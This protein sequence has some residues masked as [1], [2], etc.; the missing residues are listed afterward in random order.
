MLES[1]G[2]ARR[3]RGM[4]PER[5]WLESQSLAPGGEVS[6]Q[7]GKLRLG[8]EGIEVLREKPGWW[9][10]KL[11]V[12]GHRFDLRVTEPGRG[13]FDHPV[14]A[15]KARGFPVSV[16]PFREAYPG[17]LARLRSSMF[18]LCELSEGGRVTV[19]AAIEDEPPEVEVSGYLAALDPAAR[20]FV[21]W[22]QAASHEL[23]WAQVEA[24]KVTGQMRLEGYAMRI[25]IRST[26]AQVVTFH[27]SG[28]QYYVRTYGGC[29]AAMEHWYGPYVEGAGGHWLAQ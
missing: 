21:E 7:G 22:W 28:E 15:W 5:Q 10:R 9:S 27:R 4:S 8:L 16:G 14:T 24:R 2:G 11:A 19:R 13:T 26:G 6:W 18:E 17:L 20:R 1:A 3:R 12:V 29:I 25:G 23:Q